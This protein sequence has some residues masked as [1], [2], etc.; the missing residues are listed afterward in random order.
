MGPTYKT[1]EK[2]TTPKRPNIDDPVQMS[3][4]RISAFI[5]A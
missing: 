5:G 1:W 4:K 2:L 3:D